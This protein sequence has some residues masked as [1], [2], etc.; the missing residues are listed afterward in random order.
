MQDQVVLP[1]KWTTRAG[2]ARVG[3]RSVRVAD[4][5]CLAATPT[6]ALMAMLTGVLGGDPLDM[7]CTASRDTHAFDG[8]VSMYVLMS[9]FHS[10]PW[11]RLAARYRSRTH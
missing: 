7:L 1:E 3:A 4:W 8:M 10:A 9:L 6:F 5:L 2:S 11:L